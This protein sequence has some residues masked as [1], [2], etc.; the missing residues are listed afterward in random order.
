MASN[1]IQPYPYDFEPSP[2]TVEKQNALICID[3]SSDSNCSISSN[4]DR[5][6]KITSNQ[7][8]PITTNIFESS[9]F[10]P[11]IDTTGK[12]NMVPFDS[13]PKINN[14]VRN[15]MIYSGTNNAF[16]GEESS[17]SSSYVSPSISF[18]KISNANVI[19]PPGDSNGV[20]IKAN[21]NLSNHKPMSTKVL[22]IN[23]SNKSS[24]P[25][26][27]EID[28]NEDYENSMSKN[29]WKTVENY[30]KNGNYI[31]KFLTNFHSLPENKSFCQKLMCCKSNNLSRLKNLKKC[32]TGKSA[33]EIVDF[34]CSSSEQVDRSF[35]SEK[36][37]RGQIEK[38]SVID[39]YMA[40]SLIEIDK[41]IDLNLSLFNF[42]RNVT[43]GS[44]KLLSSSKVNDRDIP[45]IFFE[46]TRGLLIYMIK[47]GK[48]IFGNVEFEAL[49]I[50]LAPP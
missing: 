19:L 39:L 43:N 36:L 22:P 7:N 8:I 45:K 48:N 29:I 28:M 38:Y 5:L 13:Q 6:N 49:R 41:L 11:A 16:N 24:T 18:R 44:I 25:N 21:Q 15:L 23:K 4:S 30:S 34:I 10:P 26:C 37:V 27:I 2:V 47:K 31:C 1:Q 12:A 9:I 40:C 42:I 32:S 3:S 20:N 50:L 14:D 17:E 33:E 35:S 46:R